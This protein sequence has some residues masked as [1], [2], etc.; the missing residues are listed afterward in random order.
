MALDL[1]TTFFHTFPSGGAYSVPAGYSLVIHGFDGYELQVNG[2][3]KVW[4][5]SGAVMHMTDSHRLLPVQGQYFVYGHPVKGDNGSLTL[6]T[7]IGS[8]VIVTAE[9]ELWRINGPATVTGGG[10]IFARLE[11]TTSD[12]AP[13]PSPTPTASASGYPVYG[14][15]S[16]SAYVTMAHLMTTPDWAPVWEKFALVGGKWVALLLIFMAL[17]RVV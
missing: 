14:S 1:S 9:P 6:G 4:H 15:D 11:A 12:A 10:R 16:G 5:P 17:R 7:A 3:R 13:L 2:V 8:D